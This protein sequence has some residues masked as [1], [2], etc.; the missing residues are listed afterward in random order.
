M[1]LNKIQAITIILLM[2]RFSSGHGDLR[3][4]LFTS[5]QEPVYGE[6]IENLE[7]V[8]VNS[9]AEVKTALSVKAWRLV[10]CYTSQIELAYHIQVEA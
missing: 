10:I 7:I 3:T 8:E 6:G 5:S 4:A 9:Y 1:E 2:I